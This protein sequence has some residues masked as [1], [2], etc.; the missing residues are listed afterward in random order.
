MCAWF[1]FI[2]EF[3]PSFK[4]TKQT[5]VVFIFDFIILIRFNHA[6]IRLYFCRYCCHR[7]CL[8][9]SYQNPNFIPTFWYRDLS[10]MIIMMILS[11]IF[12]FF[13]VLSL[14]LNQYFSQKLGVKSVFR[15]NLDVLSIKY[16]TIILLRTQSSQRLY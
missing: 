8:W 6:L 16:R 12:L 10:K 7:I 15:L 5:I 3:I 4:I 1:W 9:D 14:F 11:L 13:I 2:C